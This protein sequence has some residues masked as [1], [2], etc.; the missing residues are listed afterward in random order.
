[1]AWRVVDEAIWKMQW[2]GCFGTEQK[3]NHQMSHEGAK[4]KEISMML[5]SLIVGTKQKKRKKE[6]TEGCTIEKYD[7][8]CKNVYPIQFFY[9]QTFFIEQENIF[10]GIK[11]HLQI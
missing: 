6:T 10:F 1:M 5:E 3:K 7:S 4:I 9:W 8:P 2:N 11:I